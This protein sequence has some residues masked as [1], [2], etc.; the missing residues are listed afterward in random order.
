M[1]GGGCH[2]LS[3]CVLYLFYFVLSAKHFPPS[4]GCRCGHL[5]SRVFVVSSSNPPP[6]RWPAGGFLH[7]FSLV[8]PPVF[9]SISTRARL[10]VVP[11][12]WLV[13]R[14][15]FPAPPR[16]TGGMRQVLEPFLP[17]LATPAARGRFLMGGFCVCVSSNCFSSHV[18]GSIARPSEV[19]EWVLRS[20]TFD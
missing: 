6:C 1:Y 8:L 17:P 9:P 11:F 18:P 16:H 5:Q 4:R 3:F 15:A 20:R 13:C 14:R 19:W 2:V 12:L 10:A 7:D